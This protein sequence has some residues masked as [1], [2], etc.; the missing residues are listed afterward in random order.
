LIAA[1]LYEFGGVG[2]QEACPADRQAP[3]DY[4]D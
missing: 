4:Q 1:T 2:L 3:L